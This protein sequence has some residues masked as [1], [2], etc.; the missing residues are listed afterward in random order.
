MLR[1]Y[2]YGGYD[3][4][5]GILKD[6]SM[7]DVTGSDLKWVQVKDMTDQDRPGPRARHT[8]V[9][10]DGKMYLFGGQKNATES[11]NSMHF[12]DFKEDEWSTLPEPKHEDS[13]PAVD[14]HSM[15]VYLAEDST[16]PSKPIVKFIVFGGF[17]GG[18]LGSYSN[19]LYSYNL[20][21][22]SWALLLAPEPGVKNPN[23]PVPR[24]GHSSVVWK[25]YYFVFG[26]YNEALGKLHDFWVTDLT[27]P[28]W[29]R[30]EADSSSQY[31]P[32]V[33]KLPNL[34]IYC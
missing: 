25:N 16:D 1:M 23:F 27:D 18:S 31:V 32:E 4:N 33:I 26:G 6:F 34:Y 28:K 5:V 30:I 29:Y 12:Y 14:S 15:N 2:V 21:S 22:G 11:T 7:I 24:S 8:A 9:V 17:F 20:A 10:H 3:F 13:I 19:N